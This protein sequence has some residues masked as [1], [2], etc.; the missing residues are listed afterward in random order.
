[1]LYCANVQAD[2]H[3]PRFDYPLME[4]S[5]HKRVWIALKRLGQ[6]RKGNP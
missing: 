3:L 1:M 2:E 6:I 5:N 4:L